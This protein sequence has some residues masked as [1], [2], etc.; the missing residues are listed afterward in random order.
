MKYQIQLIHTGLKRTGGLHGPQLIYRLGAISNFNYPK[1]SFQ[2]FAC[3]NEPLKIVFCGSD[4]FSTESF[5]KVLEYQAAHKDEITSVDLIT[6][7]PKPKGRGRTN[8]EKTE[9]QKYTDSL[10]GAKGISCYAP[11]TDEEFLQ[12]AKKRDYNL[13]IAVSYGRLIPGAFLEMLKY[14]GLNVHPSL[15]P[16]YRGAAPLHAALLNQDPFTGVSVQTLHPTKFDQGHILYQ[17]SEIPIDSEETLPSLTKKLAPLGAEGLIK[18]IG[19]KMFEHVEKYSLTSSQYQKSYTKKVSTES[20]K[21]DLESD[22]ANLVMV[23]Y[24]VFGYV[25]MFHDFMVKR[26]KQPAEL[27]CKRVQLEGLDNVSKTFPELFPKVANDMQVGEYYLDVNTKDKGNSR[28]VFKTLDGFVSAK[29]IKQETFA[30]CDANQLQ[31][32][33]KKRGIEKQQFI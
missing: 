4:S 29:S 30:A 5:K 17:T 8:C 11:E 22:T 2:S 19:E 20:R 23:K 7:L 16:R 32:S 25:Y 21:I 6:R 3:Q 27:Q 28:L 12:L 9:I 15:L 13:V 14:G 24:R 26:K 31:L 1:K 18:V 33:L 10:E